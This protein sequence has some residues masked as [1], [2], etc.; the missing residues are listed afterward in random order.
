MRYSRG[1]YK[2]LRGRVV[3]IL[4]G[5]VEGTVANGAIARRRIVWSRP[6]FESETGGRV[7][8]PPLVF[9]LSRISD[10]VCEVCGIAGV[11]LKSYGV[12]SSRVRVNK[13]KILDSGVCESLRQPVAN[14]AIARRLT[15]WTRADFEAETGD[16]VPCESDK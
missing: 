1:R 15:V 8:P 9:L 10:R 6:D 4:D 16:R 3:H 14:G 12:E 13:K 7:P 11:D 5:G 2:V